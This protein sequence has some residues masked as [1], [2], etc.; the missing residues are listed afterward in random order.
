MKKQG[1]TSA[2]ISIQLLPISMTLATLRAY[3]WKGGND[4][5]LYYKDNGK[6]EIPRAAAEAP[7]TTTTAE[8]EKSSA[9]VED[10]G[11]AQPAAGV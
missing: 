8:E 9:N 2:N 6:K 7:L 10:A 5:V 3:I 1:G 11:D 4:V